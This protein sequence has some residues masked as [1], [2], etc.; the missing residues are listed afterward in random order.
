MGQDRYIDESLRSFLVKLGGHSVE[1]A[2]GAALA[3]A[4]ASAAALMSLACHSGIRANADEG[5]TGLLA[6]CQHE[7][8]ELTRHIEHLV[9]AD[10]LAYR[11]VSEALR[12]AHGTEEERARRTERLDAALQKATEVPLEVAEAGLN[13]LAL[14]LDVHGVVAGPVLGDLAAAV[15]LAVAAV[16]GS[17]R[18]AH[19]NASALSDRTVAGAVEERIAEYRTLLDDRAQRA[20]IALSQR[21]VAG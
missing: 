2:G 18:N 7:A 20:Q 1:P 4:A 8:E 3:L 12:T 19:I 10:V 17:L 15:H 13:V 21:G 6:S 9:D 14:A 11:E 5:S 16:G